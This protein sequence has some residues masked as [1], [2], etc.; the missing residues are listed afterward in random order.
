MTV[1]FEDEIL[2]LRLR[3]SILEKE[4]EFLKTHPTIA[5]GMKGEALVAKLTKGVVGAYADQ[6]DILVGQSV[7][8]EVKF[9]KLNS[10]NPKASTKRWNWSKPLGWK[11]KGKNYDLLLLVGEKDLRFPTQYIDESPYVFFLVPHAE[12]PTVMTSGSAIGGNVQMISN[13]AKAK[14][15]SAIAIRQH[16]VP[17][18]AINELLAN[19]KDP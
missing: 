7:K 10:P 3:I 1:G 8:I 14:S 19:L 12:V 2:A 16:M 18:S 13:F 5:Q 4:I 17:E 11:D 15:L 6:H 9:S